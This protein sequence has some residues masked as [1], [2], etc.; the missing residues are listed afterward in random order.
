MSQRLKLDINAPGEIRTHGPRIRNPVL[1]PTE[2]RGHM[3]Q[4][5]PINSSLHKKN[6]APF[7]DAFAA[8]S[9]KVSLKCPR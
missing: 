2:L 9:S 3:Y 6:Q 1:Y 7:G 4:I 8:F 5:I